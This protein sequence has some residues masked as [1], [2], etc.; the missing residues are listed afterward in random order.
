MRDEEP[1]QHADLHRDCRDCER[2]FVVS[3]TEQNWFRERRM[4]VPRRCPDCRRER[5][6]ALNYLASRAT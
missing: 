3:V 2:P 1:I 6:R 5:R 4:S